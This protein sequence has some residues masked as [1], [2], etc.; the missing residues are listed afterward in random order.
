MIMTKPE[1]RSKMGSRRYFPLIIT[2][3]TGILVSAWADT[4]YLPT[5]GPSPFRYRPIFEPTTNKVAP[6]PTMP[7][8]LPV[9]LP[10][11]KP[12]KPAVPAP[13]P[14]SHDSAPATDRADAVV[15]SP[16]SDGVISPQMLLKYFNKSTNGNAASFG[17]PLDFT[18]P[19]VVD[20]P[21][22]KSENSTPSH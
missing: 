14:P 11:E 10:V 3:C 8:L 18:P 2:A 1:K 9:Q 15:E 22:S 5:V 17:A 7:A 12:E 21:S 19:H 6:P 20:S 16:Q 13:V 4:A